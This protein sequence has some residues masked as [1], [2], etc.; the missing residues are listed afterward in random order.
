MFLCKV[1]DYV[2]PDDVIVNLVCPGFAK[3]TEL[4]R[5]AMGPCQQ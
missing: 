2:S 5:P 4:H 1:A 3:A